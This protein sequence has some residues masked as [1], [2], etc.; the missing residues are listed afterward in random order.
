M[1]PDFIDAQL[2][3]ASV[4]LGAQKYPAAMKIAQQVQKQAA[5]SPLGFVLE[6]DVLMA[7]K[8]F[9]QAA[10]AY[11]TAYGMGKNGALAIKLHAAYTQAGKPQEA[12]ARLAQ[13]LKESPE[14]AMVRLYAADA[15]LKSGKYKNA[16]E[17]YEW[18]LR[19]SSPTTC[20]C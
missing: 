13:W 9:P 3:L 11:E 5:K 6:G 14:D 1:K 19:K 20:W 8:K 12:E 17:Q 2:A 10:K 4:E 16:I 15:S 18:L 7:E